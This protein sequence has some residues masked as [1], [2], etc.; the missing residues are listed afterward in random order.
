MTLQ[1]IEAA[2]VLGAVTHSRDT[3]EPDNTL[4]GPDSNTS[5]G[6]TGN[7]NVVISGLMISYYLQ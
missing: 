2:G 1:V 4:S 6:A 3:A 5:T 7:D